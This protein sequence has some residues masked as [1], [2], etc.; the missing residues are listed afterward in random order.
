MP[1]L[2]SLQSQ[3][4]P[5]EIDLHFIVDEKRRRNNLHLVDQRIAEHRAK[6]LQVI[7]ASRRYGAWQIPVSDK[8]GSVFRECRIA[9]DVVGMHVRIDD[10]ANRLQRHAAD[11]RQ[12]TRAL[13]NA[14]TGINNRNRIAAD[15][16]ADI[17]SVALIGL[18]H[19]FDVTDMNID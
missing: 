9:K 7:L 10:I 17:G 12:Q 3:Y 14:A 18:G 19:Q 2:P 13:A 6:C 16:E 5:A 15:D 4:S 1:W 8:N 11:R